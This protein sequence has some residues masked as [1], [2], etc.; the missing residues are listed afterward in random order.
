MLSLQVFVG[1]WQ[2]IGQS[3]DIRVL[4]DWMSKSPIHKCRVV[5][6]FGITVLYNP[7]LI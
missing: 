1:E 3:R 5:D 4:A 7:G 2:T 6:S